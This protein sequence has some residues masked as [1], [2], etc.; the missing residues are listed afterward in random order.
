[1]KI[2]K[3]ID[4]LLKAQDALNAKYG[5]KFKAFYDSCIDGKTQIM[6]TRKALDER[7]ARLNTDLNVTREALAITNTEV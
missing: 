2:N 6:Y 1:M 5:K 4:K 7:E 3:E